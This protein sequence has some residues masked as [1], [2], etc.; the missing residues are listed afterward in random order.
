MTNVSLI[1]YDVR[2]LTQKKSWR[3]CTHLLLALTRRSRPCY[4][5]EHCCRFNSVFK[6]HASLHR[7]ASLQWRRELYNLVRMSWIWIKGGSQSHLFKKFFLAWFFW[8][9]FNCVVILDKSVRLWCIIEYV[10]S[11]HGQSDLCSNRNLQLF[12]WCEFVDVKLWFKKPP[13]L[14]NIFLR[15]LDLFCSVSLLFSPITWQ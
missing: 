15:F 2:A 3:I 10:Q 11:A 12:W 6:T 14:L 13:I 8:S 7:Q 9:K 4:I 1:C 5:C